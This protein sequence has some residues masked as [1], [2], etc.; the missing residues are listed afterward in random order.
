MDGVHLVIYLTDDILNFRFSKILKGH[1]N[2]QV[3]SFQAV[4]IY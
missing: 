2:W 1:R 3:D 4:S